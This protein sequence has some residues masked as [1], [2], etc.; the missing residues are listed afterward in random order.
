MT[1]KEFLQQVFIVYQD[2]D[3]KLEQIA[4]LQ[5]LATRTTTVIRSTPCGNSASLFSRVEQAVLS[6]EGQSDKLADDL[7]HFMQVRD[8]VAKAIANVADPAERRLLEFRYLALLSWKEISHFMKVG[9]RT[10]YRLHDRALKNFQIG[11]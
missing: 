3:S 10:V 5:S 2:V 6:I 9:L 1:A 8:D 11:T 4:R 7:K